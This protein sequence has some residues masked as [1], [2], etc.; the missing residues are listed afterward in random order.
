MP[1]VHQLLSKLGIQAGFFALRLAVGAVGAAFGGTFVKLN[2]QPF[3]SLNNVCFG[4]W[5]ITGLV[6]VFYPKDHGSAL[7]TGQKI[8]VQGCPNTTDV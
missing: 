7:L 3:Q 2:A 8:I 4:S 6:G 1:C 5:H